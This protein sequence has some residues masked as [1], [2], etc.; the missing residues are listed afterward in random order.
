ML[1]T[2]MKFLG[3]TA[4]LAALLA[5]Q[6]MAT[7]A[8]V[9]NILEWGTMVGVPSTLTG[10]QSQ[11]P[12]RNLNGGGLAWTLT[13][14]TGELSTGGKLEI[15]VTGLVLASTLSNPASAFKA[16]VS[17]VNADGTFS[18]VSTTDSFPA[19]IGPAAS[20]GGNSKIEATVS[21]PTPCIAPIV[22]VTSTGGSWFAATGR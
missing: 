14:A 13:S 2:R 5:T 12:L 6:V 11:G 19:T 21:L 7:S 17:C 22:F 3:V 8:K 9:T 10:N 4:A 16:T 18:N 20:G 15:Q 1:S